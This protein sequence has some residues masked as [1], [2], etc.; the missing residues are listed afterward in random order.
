MPH[1]VTNRCQ[2]CKFTDCVEVCPVTCFYE[3][4]EQLVIHPDECIDCRACVDVC[5]VQA[6]YADTDVPSGYE[7]AAEF[8][9]VEARRVKETGQEGLSQ[10]K[11]PLPTA[12][13]RKAELGC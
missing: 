7:T 3:L 8:N 10:K 11:S 1:V 6:I 5:P 9:A 13:Q 12:T 2:G 4:A